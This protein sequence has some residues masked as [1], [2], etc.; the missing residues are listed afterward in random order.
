MYEL[1]NQWF[2]IE[3]GKAF[4]RMKNYPAGLRHLNF[5]EKQFQ[6]ISSNQIDFHTYCI[7]KWTLK[8][9]I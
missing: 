5:I 9:Y 6:D 8:E 3:V 4:L 1:Q 7:R 2:I